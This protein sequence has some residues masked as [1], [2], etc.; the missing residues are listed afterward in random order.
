MMESRVEIEAGGSSD[1]RV[2]SQRIFKQA[3]RVQ[4]HSI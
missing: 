1:A 2:V 4:P 3:Y